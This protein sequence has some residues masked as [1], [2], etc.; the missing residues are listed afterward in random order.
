MSQP[1]ATAALYSPEEMTDTLWH[2]IKHMMREFSFSDEEVRIILGNMPR[3]TFFKGVKHHNVTLSHDTQD[4]VSLL[5][6]IYKSLRILF[7]DSKQALTW[8]D[9]ANDLAPFNGRKPRDYMLT[10]H[11]M[12]LAEVRHF[13]D[14]WRG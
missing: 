14:Y 6:G 8:I 4:R 5:L 13:L 3:S 11:F 9:R 12:D 2:T 7:S 10:G 1:M